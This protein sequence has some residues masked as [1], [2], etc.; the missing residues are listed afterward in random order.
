MHPREI[1]ALRGMD[2]PFHNNPF[3]VAAE[4]A[5]TERYHAGFVRDGHLIRIKR[6]ERRL[7]R[8]K[9]ER[10]RAILS[11]NLLARNFALPPDIRE[12]IAEN[13][14]GIPPRPYNE[15]LQRR[16]HRLHFGKIKDSRLKKYKQD[17]ETLINLKK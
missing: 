8:Q 13:V 12:K 3:E 17:L 14:L 16:L 4:V 2:L 10:E 6:I 7:R 15:N 5:R 9:L 11:A 1:D